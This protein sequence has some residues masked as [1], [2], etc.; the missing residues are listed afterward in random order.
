VLL[1][2]DGTSADLDELRDV[3]LRSSLSNQDDR[4]DLLARPEVLDLSDISVNNGLTRVCVAPSGHIVGFLT[5]LDANEVLEIV[6]L[7]VDPDWT[8]RGIGRALVSD[9]MATARSHRSRCI[10]VTVNPQ[11]L[12]F[13]ERMGFV[14]DRN[15]E[16]T[17]G[18]AP[19]LH[20]DLEPELQQPNLWDGL[21]AGVCDNEDS[22]F[23]C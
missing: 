18:P 23:S 20:I 15:V 6:D 3:F 9:V 10:E 17:F 7:F 16:T 11:A 2:R 13:Y 22:P 12:G 1:I 4:A 5:S 19:R 14:F 21:G 8:R